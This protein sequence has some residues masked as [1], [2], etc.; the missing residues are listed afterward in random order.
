MV[1]ETRY[2]DAD[3]KNFEKTM[4]KKRISVTGS[5]FP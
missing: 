1:H 3:I 4:R 2:I 5:D